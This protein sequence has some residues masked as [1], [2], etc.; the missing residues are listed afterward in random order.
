MNY[1]NMTKIMRMNRAT[2]QGLFFMQE[3]IDKLVKNKE[4]KKVNGFFS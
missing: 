4:E 2:N 1:D 3:Q